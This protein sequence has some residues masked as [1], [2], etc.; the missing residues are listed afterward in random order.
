METPQHNLIS[1][2]S[3]LSRGLHQVE[4]KSMFLT[5]LYS[6]YSPCLYA[7]GC[8]GLNILIKMINNNKILPD[9][10]CRKILEQNCII[11]FI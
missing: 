11:M 3:L 5:Q 1:Y 6:I 4:I 7:N 10:R 9:S 2:L 8:A